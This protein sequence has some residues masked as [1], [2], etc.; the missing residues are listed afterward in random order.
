MPMLGVAQSS[1][2]AGAMEPATGALIL[3]ADDDAQVR[4]GL[5]GGLELLAHRVQTAAHGREA[6]AWLERHRPDLIVLDV[7]MPEL[8]GPGLI[9]ELR[10]RGLH[11]HVPI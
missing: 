5:A 6:L 2:A 7:N 4:S 9:A 11:P 8:D 10:R 3:V 1:Q